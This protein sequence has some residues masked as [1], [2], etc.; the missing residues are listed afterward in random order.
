MTTSVRSHDRH[1]D[2][3]YSIF[4]AFT[5]LAT[6]VWSPALVFR[7]HIADLILVSALL[8]PFA[9]I[10]AAGLYA[11]GLGRED[12]HRLARELEE[13]EAHRRIDRAHI[14]EVNSTI[15]GIASAHELLQNERR[16]G[17][18][19]RAALESM[20]RTELGR[21]G[22][23]L[24]ADGDTE[25]RPVD[26]DETIR[27]QALS[28]AVRGHEVDWLPSQRS[29]E[30]SPDDL[31]EV[32]NI[33]LD[34]AAKH[35]RAQASVEVADLTETV[36]IAVSDDGHG[37]DPAVG[38]HI[39][40]W[41]VS[42]AGSRGQGIGLAIARDLMTRQGGYLG[43]RRGGPGTTFVVGLHD[44]RSVT[45]SEDDVAARRLS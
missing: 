42:G 16:L 44:R 22:R 34:N 38:D 3:A 28:H 1:R 5:M 23:L 35:G 7:A 29:V 4:I 32:L 45:R 19:Q 6:V 10:V 26:L 15:A 8:G 12:R 36:E 2:R 17:P 43:L 39:F 25:R 20:I 41:G 37:I 14:H 27:T 13:T 9:L 21:L 31:A 24:N 40:D 18:E 30:A 33:L 11:I